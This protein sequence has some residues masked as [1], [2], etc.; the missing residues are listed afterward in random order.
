MPFVVLGELRAGFLKGSRSKVNE[1]ELANFLASA[2]VAVATASDATSR[3]YASVFDSLRR[4]RKPIPANDLWV[5]AC[6][7]EQRAALFS[8][9]S[10][11]AGVEGL[12]LVARPQDWS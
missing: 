10:H 6:A 11:F 4:R 1:A 9:D 7:I 12:L 8:F 5:A 3:V 2:H